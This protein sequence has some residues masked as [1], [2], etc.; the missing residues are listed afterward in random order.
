MTI[1]AYHS[2]AADWG[3]PLAVRPEHFARQMAM[4]ARMRPLALPEYVR[5]L[6]GGNLPHR[7]VA[8]TFDDGYADNLE[9]AGPVCR[10]L[11]I[12]PA[13]FL[14][15]GHIDSGEPL[16][17]RPETREANRPLSW[18][19]V[20]VLAEQGW[21]IGSHT[22]AHRD[23]VAAP[24]DA[25]TEELAASRARIGEMLGR[26]GDLLSYPYGRHD[27]RVRDAVA[28]AGYD[29]AFTLPNGREYH[30]HLLAVP[31][32]GVFRS[33]S[34]ALFRLKASGLLLGVKLR[35]RRPRAVEGSADLPTDGPA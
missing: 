28:A 19:Q 9:L 8:V 16:G 18:D 2:I 5:L 22:S 12:S 3:D 25:L 23:L 24:Q 30:D 17:W 34:P 11:G 15:V 29:A 33:D 13:I 26:A 35:F 6:R 21:T 14:A 20:R 32:I 7:A 10:R 31:R 27:A 4:V 1:L